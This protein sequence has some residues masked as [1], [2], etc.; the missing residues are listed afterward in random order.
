[1]ACDWH[2]EWLLRFELVV[3]IFELRRLHLI[4]Y[5]VVKCFDNLP[6]TMGS[7]CCTVQHFAKSALPRPS[8]STATWEELT[9]S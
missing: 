1:M 8:A 2:A 5:K 4:C 3:H 9:P 7:A 6:R